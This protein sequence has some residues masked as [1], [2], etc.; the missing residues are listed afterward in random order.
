M[1]GS[2]SYHLSAHIRAIPEES[3]NGDPTHAAGD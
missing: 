2:D 3:D 1:T